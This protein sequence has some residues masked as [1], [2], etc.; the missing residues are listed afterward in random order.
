LAGPSGFRPA[1]DATG[2]LV[3]PDVDIPELCG[4][5]C[6]RLAR[7][8]AA[9]DVSSVEVVGAHL[10][11]IGRLNP[12]HN[13]IVSL[14]PREEILREAAEADD[15]RARGAAGALLGLP[16][17]FKDLQ[18]TEGLK[19]TFGSPL[20]ADF[21]PEEDSL[22]VARVRAAGAIVIGKTNTPE[23]GLGSH[24][25]NTVFGRTKNAF[26]PR[27]SAG[28]SSG[29]AAVSLALRMLPIAD[30]SDFGGSLRNPEIG[31]AHV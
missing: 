16:V 29:G 5:S 13:A 28:G 25:Y 11:Q 30:G 10:D 24:T 23:F 12:A 14:R 26:D 20:F 22:T 9:K 27:L 18:P 1:F 19:T 4:E 17:A 3:A 6:A 2:R 7:M 21:V 15:A 8:L 31:R